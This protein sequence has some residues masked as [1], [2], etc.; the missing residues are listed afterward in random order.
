MAIDFF[1]ES[2]GNATSLR[3]VH[4]GFL[5]SAIGTTIITGLSK[6]GPSCCGFC[7]TAC[8]TTTRQRWIYVTAPEP[9]KAAWTRITGLFAGVSPEY[10]NEP[11]EFAA[12]WNEFGDG[13]VYAVLGEREGVTGVSLFVVLYGNAV[14]RLD[15]AADY[16]KS[17]IEAPAG[18]ASA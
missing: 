15:E 11:T 18:A 5:S 17:K 2:D 4:S 3:L 9:Q 6:V 12:S 8:Q 14:A 7:A 16:W 10:A 13:F 1:I